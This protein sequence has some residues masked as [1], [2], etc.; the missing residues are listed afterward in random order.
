MGR[1]SLLQEKRG[2]WSSF[3]GVRERI[4]AK[5]L[6]CSLYTDRGS[7]Y[8]D[9]PASGGKV[10]RDNPTQSGR[11]MARL[12]IEMIPAYSPEARG[13]SER[14]FRTHQGRLPKELAPYALRNR[15]GGVILVYGRGAG[16]VDEYDRNQSRVCPRA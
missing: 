5:G 16:P 2:I 1:A 7:H 10:D 9:T 4:E 12:G 15:G 8:W 13:R 11:A 14:A 3:P 6:F